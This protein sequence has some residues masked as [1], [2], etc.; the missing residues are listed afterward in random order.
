MSEKPRFPAAEAKAVAA[1]LLRWLD[2]AC[3]RLVVA[4]SLRREKPTVSDVEILYNAKIEKRRDPVDMFSSIAVHL[5]DEVI[6]TMESVGVLE[7]RKN[8][9]GRETFG[10]L[11]KLMRHQ[12]SGIPVDLFCEPS[13]DDW[14][15]SLVIRT[16][17][18]ELNVRLITTAAKRG[19]RVHAYGTSLTDVRGAP[20]TCE[21][22]EQFFAICG[23]RYLQP[24]DRR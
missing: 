11:N 2:P 8:T 14:W 1:E 9:I 17:P 23:A 20:I 10:P 18:K 16:G 4:G 22:E 3:E 15:R 24:K 12:A 19:I 5:A 21:S 13:L 7:R 6:A